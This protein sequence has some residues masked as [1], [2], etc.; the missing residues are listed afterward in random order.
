[1]S[2]D[3]TDL[4]VDVGILKTQTETLTS[5]CKKMDRVI[6]KIVFQQERYNAQIYEDMEKRRNEKN[7]ELK[8]VHD[9][10]D[11]VIDKVQLTEHRIK[12]EIAELRKEIAISSKKEEQS[13]AKLNEWK[14]MVAG[15]IVAVS[16]LISHVDFDMI[17]KIF[18]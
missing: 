6:E 13:I 8:E 18:K 2:D 3:I 9:R 1:M 15:G 12:E 11:T 17:E 7:V 14:W 10:I 16:W 5:L 4:K